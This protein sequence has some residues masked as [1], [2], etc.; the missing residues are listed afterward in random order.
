MVA[1]NAIISVGAFLY[2]DHGE[3]V[4]LERGEQLIGQ[5]TIK[6]VRI[7]VGEEAWSTWHGYWRP[8]D[9]AH[10]SYEI[11]VHHRG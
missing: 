7:K 10:H 1:I 9:E 3:R 8:L 5:E 6:L 4:V 2:A 11:G